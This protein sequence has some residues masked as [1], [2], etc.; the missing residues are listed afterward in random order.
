M[1]NLTRNEI[2]KK[3]KNAILYVKRDENPLY[4]QEVNEDANLRNDLYLDSLN[5]ADVGVRLEEDEFL[6]NLPGYWEMWPLPE[7]VKEI[8][9]YLDSLE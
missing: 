3:V 2:L 5:L 6:M 7:T 8:V 9:D 4:N 1:K